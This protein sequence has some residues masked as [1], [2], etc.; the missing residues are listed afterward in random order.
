MY[1]LSVYSFFLFSFFLLLSTVLL[2]VQYNLMR[3]GST[4]NVNWMGS[5]H[6]TSSHSPTEWL[7]PI[8]ATII[9]LQVLQCAHVSTRFYN[10]L[11]PFHSFF[12]SRFDV[13]PAN[14]QLLSFY[15]IQVAIPTV[16]ITEL[17]I[18]INPKSYWNGHEFLYA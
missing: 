16:S 13:Q 1:T 4:R 9:I 14:V 12:C 7:L 10:N 17:W 11:L 6:C 18:W 3:M 2:L 15:M 5:A 8:I